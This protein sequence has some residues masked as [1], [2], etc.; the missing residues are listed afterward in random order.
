L[1][2]FARRNNQEATKPD[3]PLTQ[4]ITVITLSICSL[5]FLYDWSPLAMPAM[6][7]A[8]SIESPGASLAFTNIGIAFFG[9][10]ASVG[11]HRQQ[12]FESIQRLIPALPYD[13]W[14]RAGI[15]KP[16]LALANFTTHCDRQLDRCLHFT[17]YVNVFTAK[18][19]AW[20]DRFVIDG[21]VHFFVWV[22]R[23]VGNALRQLVTGRIQDYI[24]W[25]VVAV[26]ILLLILAN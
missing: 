3:I 15:V 7:S 20:F 25:T 12:K 11:F 14:L 4:F 21:C 2:L 5:W 24:W 23:A 19:M 8:W 16:I 26:I 17:V 6:L 9:I 10:A 18:L 1:L 22:T 13:A